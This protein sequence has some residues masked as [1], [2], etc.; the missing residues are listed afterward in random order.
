MYVQLATVGLKLGGNLNTRMVYY[1]G[2]TITTIVITTVTLG[3]FN[4]DKKS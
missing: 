2:Q 3:F 4:L 1:I